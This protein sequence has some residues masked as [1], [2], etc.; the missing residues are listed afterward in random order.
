MRGK[1]M[2][3]KKKQKNE[4]EAR[5]QK[6]LGQAI[7]NLAALIEDNSK[8]IWKSKIFWTQI[9]TA[10]GFAILVVL[11]EV[12]KGPILAGFSVALTVVLRKVT[13]KAIR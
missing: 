12:D 7:K 1:K 9:G 6:R 2:A 13:N 5:Q 10:V 4:K 8:P 3:T 11:G